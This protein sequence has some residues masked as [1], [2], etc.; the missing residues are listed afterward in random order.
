M[1][2]FI[3]PIGKPKH[4]MPINLNLVIGYDLDK[5]TIRFYI[6]EEEY[7]LWKYGTTLEAAE[8][9]NILESRTCFS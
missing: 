3:R 6:D 2:S 1:K 8:A 7:F 4:E 5:D 9:Y